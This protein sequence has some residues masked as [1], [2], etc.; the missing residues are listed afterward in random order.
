M[1]SL[2]SHGH[3]FEE[4]SERAPN[5]NMANLEAKEKQD[6]QRQIEAS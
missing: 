4:T 1:I 3:V 5:P 2:W 6:S